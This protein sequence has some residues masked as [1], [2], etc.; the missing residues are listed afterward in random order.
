M[1]RP[2][3]IWSS[4]TISKE[5]LDSHDIKIFKFTSWNQA[6]VVG[7]AR[8]GD[9]GVTYHQPFQNALKLNL[10]ID[11]RNDS[12]IATNLGVKSGGRVT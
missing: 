4:S 9:F 8:G 10:I 1:G 11:Y 2:N 6:D 12:R 3:F 7:V 5:M